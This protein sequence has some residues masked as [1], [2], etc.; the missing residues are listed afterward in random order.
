MRKRVCALFTAI[1]L[2]L[3]L[4]L[5]GIALPASAD[6][7]EDLPVGNGIPEGWKLR[8]AEQDGQAGKTT[9]AVVA[10]PDDPDNNVLNM[11]QPKYR[12]GTYH[13]QYGFEAT[14]EPVILEYRYRIASGTDFTSNFPIIYP[15]FF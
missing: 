14:D 15:D 2:L 13:L 11:Y 6:I 5:N 1:C 8:N 3:G 10:D 4:A 9:A 7:F 12:F